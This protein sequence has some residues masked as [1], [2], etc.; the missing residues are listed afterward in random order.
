[1]SGVFVRSSSTWKRVTRVWVR[2]SGL[3]RP[4]KA[5]Y[6]RA[7][8]VWKRVHPDG[9]QQE[10]LA[11]GTY[12][13]VVPPGVTGIHA[14]VVAPGRQNAS[15]TGIRRSGTVLISS[16]STIGTAFGGGNGGAGGSAYSGGGGGAGGYSGNGGA[17]HSGTGG[18]YGGGS[19]GAGGGGG[20]GASAASSGGQHGGGVYLHGAGKSGVG[21]TSGSAP[22]A[23][24]NLGEGSPRGGGRKGITNDSAQQGGNLRYTKTAITVTPGEALEV[25]IGDAVT[26]GDATT[27]GGVRI[28][29]GAGRSYPSNAKDV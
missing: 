2:V 10:W 24:S 29:W 15:L 27:N 5:V 17:G 8:G 12:S 23:G 7:G 13:F 4:I 11:G 25:S 26:G 1:M 18:V 19:A 14:A 3:W 6:V 22:G 21:G 16:N 9:G 28:I 20:G